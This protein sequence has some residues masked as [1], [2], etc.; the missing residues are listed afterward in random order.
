MVKKIVWLLIA[1]LII[2]GGIY[3]YGASQ[4]QAQPENSEKDFY[5]QEE[6]LEIAKNWV[7]QE[8]PTYTYDGHD[9]EL[10]ESRA[11]DLVDCEDCYEFDFTFISNH[12]G[13]GNRE[14][15]MVTQV[16]T[17]HIITVTVE[18]GEVSQAVT[19]NKF[20]EMTA[21][22]RQSEEDIDSSQAQIVNLYYYNM[23]EEEEDGQV[24]CDRESVLPVERVISGKEPIKETIELL[25]EGELKS[26]EEEQGF[27]TEFPHKEFKLRE[28]NLEDG[29]L[30]LTFYEVPGFTTGGSCRVNLLRAQIEKTALQFPEVEEVNIEPETLFQP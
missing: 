22:L 14:G 8:S 19:D 9:L 18:N 11:L 20:D 3:W 17:P 27:E 23:T 10:K 5:T 30:T 12:G 25:L 4:E 28:T 21:E 26:Q 24:D 1:V 16:I 15:Q 7:K 29:T 2:L 6:S 13:F